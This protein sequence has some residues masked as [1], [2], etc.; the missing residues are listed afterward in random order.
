M[1]K[2]IYLFLSLFL[3]SCTKSVTYTL[4]RDYL[5]IQN[6]RC[7]VATFDADDDIDGNINN[8]NCLTAAKLFKNQPEV[9]TSFWCE[10]GK[11]KK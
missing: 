10:K 6:V 9:N 1:I 2:S 8:P 11:F 7:H 3:F 4:Y 5:I